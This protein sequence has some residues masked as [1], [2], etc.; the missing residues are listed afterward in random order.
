MITETLNIYS[1]YYFFLFVLSDERNELFCKSKTE[2]DYEKFFNLYDYVLDLHYQIK[3]A[4]RKY[5]KID[6]ISLKYLNMVNM[7]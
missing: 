7:S 4:W 3:P 1:K 2:L 6:L 5:N